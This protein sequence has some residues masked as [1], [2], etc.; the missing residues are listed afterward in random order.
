M[1]QVKYLTSEDVGKIF[2]STG[3]ATI[4]IG[5]STTSIHLDEPILRPL[6][7]VGNQ[8]FKV[9]IDGS[10]KYVQFNPERFVHCTNDEVKVTLANVL[11]MTP[12][13]KGI[14]RML[15]RLLKDSH[16]THYIKVDVTE[17]LSIRY[18]KRFDDRPSYVGKWYL[19][20]HKDKVWEEVEQSL[21]FE[22]IRVLNICDFTEVLGT[23]SKGR[24]Y[25]TEIKHTLNGSTINSYLEGKQSD[26]KC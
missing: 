14:T 4:A 3:E 7:Y 6:V 23:L 10:S 1:I 17:D 16:G 18:I 15:Q 2:V 25:K 24:Y 9:F 11:N 19:K 26:T 12:K 13:Q 20:S 22:A 8:T 21:V 5:E